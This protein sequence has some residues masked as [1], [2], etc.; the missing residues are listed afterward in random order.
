MFPK[1]FSPINLGPVE[2]KN[3][4]AM[5]AFGLLYSQDRHCNDRMV[6]FYEARAKGGSGLL[7]VGGV[8]I[9]ML[10]SGFILTSI[11]SDDHIPGWRKLADACHKHGTKLFLQLFHAGRYTHSFSIGGKQAVAPSVVP[12]RYTRNEEPRALEISEI[13]EIQEMYAAAAARAKEAGCDGVEIISS[14]GYLISQFLSPLT[15]LREDEY[16]G[17][18]ENR[19][20]F[21]VEVIKKVK[22]RVGD[23]FAV[24]ARV[25]GNDFVPGSNTNKESIEVCKVYE[26]AGVHGFNVTGGW[27][28]TK[29]PQLPMMVP[30][31]AFTYLALGIRKAVNVPVLSSNRIV[32]PEHAESVLRDGM[33]DMLCIGRSQIAD[34]EWSNKAQKGQSKLIRPCVGCM[35]GCMDQLF[36][37]KSVSCLCNPQAGMEAER[38]VVKAEQSKKVA[39]IGAG[40]GGLE[41]A[42]IACE[43]GHD[44]TLY[45]AQDHIG[46]QL[47]LVAAPPERDEFGSLQTYYEAMLEELD[48][49]LKLGTKADVDTIKQLGPDVVILASGAE[50]LIPKLPGADLPH[51]VSAWDVLLDK[52]YLGP[53]VVVIGGGAVGVETAIL[54][55]SKGTINGETLKFL[56]K[57][58]AET[59]DALREYISRGSF[60]VAILEMLPKIGKDLGQTSRWVMLKELDIL[61]VTTLTGATVK[62]IREGEV[63]FS[64]GDEEQSLPADSVVLALGARPV[65]ELSEKLE[66]A[67]L[68]VIKIGDCVSPRK[69]M[70][71]IHEGFLEAAKI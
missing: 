66:Q 17:S 33:A 12:S 25:A 60:E 37:G 4:I 63:I 51:V 48:I 10:G 54:V 22:E 58:D 29:V 39:V 45:E 3:R 6:D 56:F 71:A 68:N 59:V 70:D 8:G 53:K 7:I 2:I 55:G 20:R 40:P 31:G 67:G 21:G 13:H 5:P 62:E 18:F 36:T 14:A 27:H 42:I 52:A 30:R 24:T 35:Q 47:P 49:D 57:H 19:T 38:Q 41:T 46:G 15:N 50:A 28:E 69:V 64:R 1:L 32:T 26:A 43:R 34:P 65:D 16:G 11:E 61:G 9:D 44:V 23:D